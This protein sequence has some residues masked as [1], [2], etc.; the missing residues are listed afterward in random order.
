MHVR[1][2]T[3]DPDYGAS[4][5]LDLPATVGDVIVDVERPAAQWAPIGSPSGA[6]CEP[7]VLFVDGV[8]RTD[9]LGWIDDDAPCTFASY[10]AGVV[11]CDADKASVIEVEV[12]RGVAS[13]S[14]G[15]AALTT[16]AGTFRPIAAA[17]CVAGAR[18]CPQA[19]SIRRAR[20]WRG[21]LRPTHRLPRA[22]CRS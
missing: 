16:R 8:R 21:W 7:V 15:L 18:S 11:R 3:W 6:V 20:N 17:P 19:L 13:A 12:D 9:A 5:E 4:S 14:S 1:V 2:D 10:A 22:A